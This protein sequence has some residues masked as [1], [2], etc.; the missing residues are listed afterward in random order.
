MRDYGWIFMPGNYDRKDRLYQK[1][2]DEG[3]RSRASYKLK[4]LNQQFNIVKHGSKILDLGAWPGGWMQ[5][6]AELV[7]SS[8]KIVGIDLVAIDTFSDPRI[9]EIQGDVREEKILED[10]VKFAGGPFDAVVSDMSPKLTGIP[11]VDR[12]AAV[13]LN[14]L[15]FWACGIT[16]K[17]GGNFIT[18]VFKGN[19]TEVFVKSIRPVFNKVVRSELDATRKTSNEFY[20]VALG[21]KRTA[22]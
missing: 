4:E 9:L 3:Y 5:V 15:A 11:E 19:E 18:K 16:L 20:V 17:L 10:A 12:T 6:A 13:G 22:G 7:G 8:G 2:K 1:A 21:Y 14:E